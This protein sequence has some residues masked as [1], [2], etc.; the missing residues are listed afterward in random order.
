MY[1]LFILL[2]IVV[3]IAMIGRRLSGIENFKVA[4]EG[5]VEAGS[6]G[7]Y[8]W[9]YTP[10]EPPG[11]KEKKHWS[12]HWWHK[13]KKPKHKCPRCG[14]N[15]VINIFDIEAGDCGGCDITRHPDID[16]YVLK[17]SVPPCPDMSQFAKKKDMCPC[18]DMSKYVRKSA[19][20]P[21]GRSDSFYESDSRYML[22]TD[23]ASHEFTPEED[24]KTWLSGGKDGQWW[25]DRN[26]QNWPP[27]VNTTGKIPQAYNAIGEIV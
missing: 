17:S 20:P 11:R 2:A 9:G 5:Q 25:A 22:K 19:L 12:W 4:T 8:S 13:K 24:M 26:N 23:C 18:I 3:M 1:F 16:K 7:A 14:H 6:S 27:K 21:M 10:I 15:F